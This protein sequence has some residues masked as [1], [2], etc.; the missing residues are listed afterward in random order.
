MV[1]GELFIC[2]IV[3]LFN[4]GLFN[5]GLFNC[6]MVE[7]VCIMSSCDPEWGQTTP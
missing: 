4:G 2:L 7:M 5:G 6:G 3:Y 1:N